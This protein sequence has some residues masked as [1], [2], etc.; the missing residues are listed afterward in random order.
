MGSR[1]QILYFIGLFEHL[2]DLKLYDDRVHF[3]AE[4]ADDQTPIPPFIPPLR[5]RLTIMYFTRVGL[6]ED[7]IDQFGGIR[8]HYMDLYHVDGIRLLLDSCAKTLETLRLYPG[9]PRG[10]EISLNSM[11]VLANDFAAISSLRD[12][13][14]SRN[15]SLRTLE[16]RAWYPT[17]THLPK[18]ALSTI[19]SPAFSE[20]IVVYRES[21]FPGVEPLQPNSPIFRQLLPAERAEETLWHERQFKVFR[22]MR[23]IRG[24][25]LV[26]CADVWDGVKE[27]T[28]RRLRQAVAAE[29]AKRGF[30]NTFPEPLVGYSRRGSRRELTKRTTD[31]R[32]WV[33][34]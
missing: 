12:F 4:P 14:L 6:L 5:G 11:Q 26:L 1:R 21:D 22:T 15:K 34:L 30:D 13:D 7:M 8:F 9:D 32:P 2:E 20:V 31:P 23:K 24:F 3:R 17:G 19:T 29:K 16:I 27:Y 33:P 10:K 28:I 25:Q 18:Y